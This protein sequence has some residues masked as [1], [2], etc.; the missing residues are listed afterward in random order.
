MFDRGLLL[1]LHAMRRPLAAM[2]HDLYL[3]GLIHHQTRRA[4]PGERLWN[5]TQLRLQQPF[6][7]GRNREGCDICIQPFSDNPNPGYTLVDL[8]QTGTDVIPRM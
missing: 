5:A 7:R 2:P 8:D 1:T 3:I 4:F 6:L